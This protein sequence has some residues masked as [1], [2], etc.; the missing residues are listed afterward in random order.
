MVSDIPPLGRNCIAAEILICMTKAGICNP[1]FLS[2]KCLAAIKVIKKHP[3]SMVEIFV[4]SR[5]ASYKLA[6]FFT[7]SYV[8]LN[9]RQG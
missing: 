1:G 7:T 6:P 5:N 4:H 9:L 3:F 8:T 2:D